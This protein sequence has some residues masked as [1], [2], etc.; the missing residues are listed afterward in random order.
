MTDYDQKRYQRLVDRC[1]DDGVDHLAQLRVFIDEG[2]RIYRRDFR[3]QFKKTGSSWGFG[4]NYAMPRMEAWL[5]CWEKTKPQLHGYDEYCEA[6]M[7]QEMM[8]GL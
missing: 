5:E 6:M 4:V 2:C 1:F 7:A 3:E 8:N